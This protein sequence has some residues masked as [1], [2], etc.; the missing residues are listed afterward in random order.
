MITSIDVSAI[1]DV[2]AQAFVVPAIPAEQ[3][4]VGA[5]AISSF[6]EKL[7]HS[8]L[9]IRQSI[10]QQG[11]VR[12]EAFSWRDTKMSL[13]IQ[14]VV[15]RRAAPGAELLVFLNDRITSHV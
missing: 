15:N 6:D 2:G 4:S 11:Q 7:F 12:T 3:K 5:H 9:A 13:G 1:P 14:R 8:C 10:G